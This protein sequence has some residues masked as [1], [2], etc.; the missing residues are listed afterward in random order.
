M[1]KGFKSDDH[2]KDS[3]RGTFLHPVRMS[4]GTATGNSNRTEVGCDAIKSGGTPAVAMHFDAVIIRRVTYAS[5]PIFPPSPF[6]PSNGVSP[7]FL[8]AFFDAV[9]RTIGFLLADATVRRKKRRGIS[10]PPLSDGGE[11][12]GGRTMSPRG[13]RLR[14]KCNPPLRDS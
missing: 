11:G 12:S 9:R 10:P 6:H 1:W 7:E 3:T 14:H 13:I 4:Q 5:L 8:N 2:N